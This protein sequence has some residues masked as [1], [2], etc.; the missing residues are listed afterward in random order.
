MIRLVILMLPASLSVSVGMPYTEF[1]YYFTVNLKGAKI[2][3]PH[4]KS[5]MK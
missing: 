2:A 3:M 4:T 1:S 5:G